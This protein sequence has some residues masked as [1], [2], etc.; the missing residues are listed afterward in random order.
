M[1]VPRSSYR[2]GDIDNRLLPRDW[3]T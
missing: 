3:P 1:I 2:P